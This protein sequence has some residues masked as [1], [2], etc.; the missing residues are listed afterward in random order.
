MNDLLLKVKDLGIAYGNQVIL[1]DVNFEMYQNEVWAIVGGVGAGKTSLAKALTGRLFRTGEVEF[2]ALGD[3]KNPFVL[4]VDQQHQFKNRSNVNE[5]YLQQRFNSADSQDSYTIKEELEEEDATKVQELLELFHLKEHW[6]KPLLQLS[7]GENK[8]LQIIKALL[9]DPDY[10]IFDNPYLGLDVAG[11]S[12]LTQSLKQLKCQGV[13]FILINSPI[14][15]PDLVDKVLF[16][17]HG[18][19]M[20]KGSREHYSSQDSSL[21]ISENWQ[22][23]L[24]GLIQDRNQF[25]DF[26]VAVK[27]EE[28]R[29]QYQDKVILNQ[30]NWLINKGD[31]WAIKGP[32]GAGKSTL[33]SMIT[34]DNPQSYSQKLWLF[35][36]RRG[37]G[38]SI[39]DIKKRIGFVSPELHLYFKTAATCLSV[40]G[41]GLFDTIGLFKKLSDLQE[42]RVLDWMEILGI[43]HL[44]NQYFQRISTGEQRLVLLARAFVKNPP[45]LILDEPC[46]GLDQFQIEHIKNIIDFLAENSD[47]TLIYV[48]HYESDIPSCVKMRYE[49]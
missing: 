5:F 27:M 35:D 3:R 47:M 21:K 33:I 18:K 11:R 24:E 14:D 46:Q 34:A 42:K 6:N 2:K 39:W 44:Q 48:S 13:P 4:L 38:E 49:L 12:L 19:V 10:L 37:S 22:M 41:S 30:V 17:E 16:L 25:S 32:N 36:R 8:R 28:A 9:K 23:K 1:K 31:K 45:L 20:W 7:N 43:S 40:I 29:I 26:E 15:L